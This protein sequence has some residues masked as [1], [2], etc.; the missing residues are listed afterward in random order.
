MSFLTSSAPPSFSFR[1]GGSPAAP[2]LPSW[3]VDST[4]V[5][6][7]SRTEYRDPATGLQVIVT[8]RRLPGFAALEWVVEFANLGANDT[9]VIEDILALDMTVPFPVSER[10]RLH[11]A[12]G[13]LCQ[14]D[15]FLPQLTELRAGANKTLAPR[16]GRSSNGTLPFMNLQRGDGGMIIAVGWSGQWRAAFE[17][18][19]DALHVTAGMEHT[20]L[21]L[22]PGEK[23]RSPRML[24]IDWEGSEWET[25]NNLLR[26]AL[27]AH[28]M[29]RI[30]GQLVMPPAAQCLQF[31][32]YLTN[33][34]SEQYEMKAQPRIAESGAEVHWIDACWYGGTGETG[35]WW[36]QVGSW[37]INRKRFPHGLRPISDGARAR[38]LK[39]VLWYEPERV[40]PNTEIQ[41]DHPEFLVAS[42]ANPTNF[43]F[44]LGNPG[45]RRWLTDLLSDGI[46]EHGIDI[47]RQD[48]NF[49]PLVYWQ[50]AD[51]AE[52]PD[53]EG[54][55]EIRYI[56]GLYEMW[57]ELRARHPGLWIDNCASG[58]RRIDLETMSRSLPLWPSDFHD[59]YGMIFGL[60]LH[61]GDQCINAGLA[62]WVPL[63][64]G[65]AWNFTPYGTRGEIIGGFML[66][67]HIDHKDF[68]PDDV[69]SAA[70][71][72][73]VMAKGK[74]VLDD[75]YPMAAAQAAI[76]EWRSIR[77]FFLGDFYHLLPLTVSY[78]DW[79]AWQLHRED[80]GA[81]VAVFFRRHRSP[82]AEMQASLKQIDPA[83]QYDVSLSPAYEEAPCQHMT[84][85][86]LQNLK[87][88]IDEAPGSVLVRYT[89]VA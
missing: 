41:R 42:D 85:R 29:P 34:A 9:P 66:G 26:R 24:L 46:T 84:G 77:P 27:L 61:V 80:L 4:S 17:R 21:R 31:Y 19:Q 69:G 7:T 25:G 62:H 78:H 74:T 81:G 22:H 45:A 68:P 12:N 1:Y 63:F 72:L 11:H 37:S 15:D 44:N 40:Q 16:G 86:Q 76:A 18:S 49:D 88:A 47:Y 51:A 50:V 65:G 33:Q 60:G 79:C 32:F 36:Q 10:L 73:E 53:R 67:F 75:D 57:D 52:G 13:S 8:A 59:A 83:G 2:L 3:E 35:E 48:H 20:R 58:G 54:I 6:N 70:K 30:D 28:Y 39:F 89:K 87:I 23:I 5:G 82:F 71:A 55:S 56:T 38:G 43:L 14:M 64:G